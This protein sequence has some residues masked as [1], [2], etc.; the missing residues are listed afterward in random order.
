ML[1]YGCAPCEC[2]LVVSHFVR[3]LVESLDR[4]DIRVV[5]MGTLCIL[6]PSPQKMS[7]I[8]PHM[9]RMPAAREIAIQETRA[10]SIRYGFCRRPK[11]LRMIQGIQSFSTNL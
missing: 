1:L 3:I 8:W 11:E 4:R 6:S 2:A 7:L 5:R 10:H 9:L